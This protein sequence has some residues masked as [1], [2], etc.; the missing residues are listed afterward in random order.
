MKQGGVNTKVSG[1]VDYKRLRKL[2][3]LEDTFVQEEKHI[4]YLTKKMRKK[5]E[6]RKKLFLPE[7]DFNHFDIDA[8]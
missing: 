2:K 6:V 1:I 8:E 5:T 7:L 4:K 3:K